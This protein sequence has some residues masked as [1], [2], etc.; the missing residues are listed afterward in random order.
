M[1]Q[2]SS[3]W[4]RMRR[5]V[6]PSPVAPP[7][8]APSRPTR[9]HTASSPTAVPMVTNQSSTEKLPFPILLMGFPH[10][11]AVSPHRQV[12]WG[13]GYGFAEKL[14]EE[15]SPCFMQTQVFGINKLCVLFII[16]QSQREMDVWWYRILCITVSRIVGALQYS[17]C[18]VL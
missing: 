16:D 6:P 18:I 3:Y 9:T 14:W 5:C 2:R 11:K 1:P 17:H 12:G 13:K 15:Y 8:S 7:P 4:R 10:L